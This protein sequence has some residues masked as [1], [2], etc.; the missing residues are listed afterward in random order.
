MIIKIIIEIISNEDVSRFIK[1]LFQ[2]GSSPART[3]A[4]KMKRN[5]I[6]A[7]RGSMEVLKK[8]SSSRQTKQQ[9]SNIR[10]FLKKST[11]QT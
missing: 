5:R 3:R 10:Y 7:K 8:Y 9:V 4:I 11:L 1:A 2:A 6:R